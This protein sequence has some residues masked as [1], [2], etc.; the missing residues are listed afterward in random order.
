MIRH[1]CRDCRRPNDRTLPHEKP[2]RILATTGR[3]EECQLRHDRGEA[4]N[5][6]VAYKLAESWL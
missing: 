1:L 2:V 3:C 4:A 5:E 6:Y